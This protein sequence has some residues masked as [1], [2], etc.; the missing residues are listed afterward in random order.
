MMNYHSMPYQGFGHHLPHYHGFCRSCC[1]PMHLCCCGV[2]ECRKIPK[3]LLV[4]AE[5][6]RAELEIGPA[7]EVEKE[8]LVEAVKTTKKTK[9]VQELGPAG[10]V[11]KVPAPE[12]EIIQQRTAV[13]GGGCC[14]HLSVEYFPIVGA[15]SAG[16]E[17]KVIDSDGTELVWGKRQV[18]PGYHI[19][20]GV[21]TTRPGAILKALAKDAIVRVR[22]CEVIAC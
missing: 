7:G 3:E 9:L 11:E 16:L 12:R 6:T 21:I 19:K 4:V 15:K 14:V 2:R 8:L 1:H 10:E 18:P 5:K 22:W 13:I 17:V 20:E